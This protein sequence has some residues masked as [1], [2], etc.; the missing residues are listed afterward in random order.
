M[1]QVVSSPMWS[2]CVLVEVEVLTSPSPSPIHH[3]IFVFY[4]F[5]S[6]GNLC[7]FWL[8][9]NNRISQFLNFFV[10][11]LIYLELTCL[12]FTGLTTCTSWPCTFTSSVSLSFFSPSFFWFFSS[13]F[14]MTINVLGCCSS[15]HR[16]NLIKSS[17]WMSCNVVVKALARQREETTRPRRQ[18]WTPAGASFDWMM[19]ST[20]SW[21]GQRQQKQL[22]RRRR[23]EAHESAGCQWSWTAWR[24][25]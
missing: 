21:R 8:L 13:S 11:G 5:F 3:F 4:S 6:F 15:R 9:F 19:S 24:R 22:T 1:N 17:H 12:L 23:S 7:K 16:G 18:R 2:I 10:P 14:A 25:W 20:V